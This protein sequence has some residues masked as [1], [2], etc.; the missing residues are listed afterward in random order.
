MQLINSS[1]G[2]AYWAFSHANPDGIGHLWNYGAN[3][4]GWED[5]RG[6]GDN[7]FNDMIVQLDFTSAAGHGWLV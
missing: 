6:G 1:H 5:T 3:T 2:D 7:D 4:W